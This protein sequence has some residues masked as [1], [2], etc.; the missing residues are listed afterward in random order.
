MTQP[1]PHPPALTLPTIDDLFVD[2]RTLP[3]PPM[4]VLEIMRRS[5]DPDVVMSD[6]V[7]LVEVDVSIAVQVLR[8][9]NSALYS[10]VREITTIGRAMTTLGLR[11]IRLL[12]LTTSLRSL[13][14]QQSE[15]IDTVDIR[16]RMVINGSLARRCAELIDSSKRDEAFL[17]GLLTGIGPVVLATR[18][19][20]VC[21]HLMGSAELWPDPTTERDLLGFTSDDVTAQL[22]HQ[23]ALPEIFGEAIAARST[24]AETGDTTLITCLRLS[25]LVERVLTGRDSGTALGELHSLMET[26]T[27]M[28]AEAVDAWLLESEPVVAETAALLQFRIPQSE[29]YSQLLIEATE[30]MLALQYSVESELLGDGSAAGALA[31]RNDELAMEA[32]T[33]ALTQLPNRRSFDTMLATLVDRHRSLPVD[34]GVGLGL[35]MLD[36]DHFKQVNDSFGHSVGDDVLRMVGKLLQRLIRGDDFAARFGGEEFVMLIPETTNANLATIAERLRV[37]VGQL[38][39]TLDGG[40]RLSV[41]ASI[42]GALMHGAGEISD[43][44]SLIEAADRQLYTAK[45]LGRNR[46]CVS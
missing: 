10:P 15:V 20:D 43:G 33:D 39:I 14:P 9:A 1:L 30:R 5:E 32:A 41:S 16:R 37:A 44:R 8:M 26:A 45:Q 42:G 4:S 31:R 7:A 46:T 17:A 6:I 28:P 22:V 13:I 29:A 25:L 2:P 36:L 27:G 18:A 34:G 3:A 19:P 40:T 11:T 12:A 38:A 24:S 21:R 35:L 23:W